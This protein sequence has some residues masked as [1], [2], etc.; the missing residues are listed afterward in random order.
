MGVTG[1][2]VPKMAK[3]RIQLAIRG[4]S[5]LWPPWTI[6]AENLG[7]NSPIV[8]LS[9]V[10]ISLGCV[11]ARRSS[12]RKLPENGPKNQF[13]APLDFF[14]IWPGETSIL[15]CSAYVH[16]SHGSYPRSAISKYSK[17]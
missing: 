12:G 14:G 9:G 7:D 13:S 11:E 5:Y 15:I 4:G 3:K 10:Q 1:K 2:N 16:I 8:G 17:L 6:L